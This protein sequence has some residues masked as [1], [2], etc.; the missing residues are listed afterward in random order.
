M[1]M[2]RHRIQQG[3]RALLAFSL[4]VDEALARAYLTP[5]LMALFQ[6]MLRSE[7]LHSL[8]VLRAVLAQG[9]TPRDLAA[10]ALLHDAGKSRYPLR[11]WQKTLTVLVRAFIPPLY[12]RWQAGSPAHILQ[13]PFVV[14]ACHPAWSAEMVAAAGAS[15]RTIWLIAHHQADAALWQHHPCAPLLR[16]LQQADDAN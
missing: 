1:T 7:R 16:R 11:V 6:G 8:N 13:R 2:A 5:E 14:A 15:E 3:V 12:R 10:A 9:D 4:P